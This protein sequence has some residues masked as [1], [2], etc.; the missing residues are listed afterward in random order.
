MGLKLNAKKTKAMFFHMQF[1]TITTSGGK[2]SSKHS[3]KILKS[4]ALNT[5]VIGVKKQEILM[6]GRHLL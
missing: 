4:N 2:K 5:L 3:Q 6:S 1:Q